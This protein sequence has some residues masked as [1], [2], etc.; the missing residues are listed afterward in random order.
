MVSAEK[1]SALKIC[2][3]KKK[4][5]HTFH[6]PETQYSN[7][8]QLKVKQTKKKQLDIQKSISIS[9]YHFEIRKKREN[10]HFLSITDHFPRETTRR[11]QFRESEESVLMAEQ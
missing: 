7:Q 10:W 1:I 2:R 3:R 4:T 11:K 8:S 6:T 9:L 5:I